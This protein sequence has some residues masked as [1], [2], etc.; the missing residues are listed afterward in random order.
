MEFSEGQF[1]DGGWNNT[2][3]Y[4]SVQLP[5]HFQ[6]QKMMLLNK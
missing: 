5:F 2:N 3:M 4:K 6:V 1:Y